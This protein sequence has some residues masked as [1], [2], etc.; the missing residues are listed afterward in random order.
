MINLKTVLF[1]VDGGNCIFIATGYDCT[2]LVTFS[3]YH[4]PRLWPRSP[5]S[6]TKGL[7]EITLL[8]CIKNN[9]PR[10]KFDWLKHGMR[11]YFPCG[12]MAANSDAPTV[13]VHNNTYLYLQSVEHLY[14]YTFHLCVA[15][16]LLT[17]GCVFHL[18]GQICLLCIFTIIIFISCFSPCGE[19]LQE[20]NDGLHCSM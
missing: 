6:H 2:C 11:G 8:H 1:W 16:Y 14:L 7:A 13:L 3:P 19:K 4:S 5:G 9:L 10:G 12:R 17:P 18:C 15:S 20:M